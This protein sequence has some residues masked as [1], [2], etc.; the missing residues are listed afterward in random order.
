MRILKLRVDITNL[1][2]QE[3]HDLE[4]ALIAQLEN[5]NVGKHT[6]EDDVE[7]DDSMD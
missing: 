5:L 4:C 6:I 3:M 2:E 1:S 7:D